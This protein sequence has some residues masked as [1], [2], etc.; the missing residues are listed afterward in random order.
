MIDRKLDIEAQYL[1]ARIEALV[2]YYEDDVFD[3]YAFL[4][5][6]NIDALEYITDRFKKEAENL[7]KAY[8]ETRSE[9]A[10]LKGEVSRLTSLVEDL[11]NPKYPADAVTSV[12]FDMFTD[13]S[14]N[15]SHSIQTI[16]ISDEVNDADT[17]LA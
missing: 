17:N 4:P 12:I 9:N 1:N 10:K 11:E 3:Y 6:K 2:E 16:D 8:H 7:E 5:I 14:Q 15:V 13:K